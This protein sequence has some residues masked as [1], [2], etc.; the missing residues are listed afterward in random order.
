[1][2][3]L[4]PNEA[5][6]L[7][8]LGHAYQLLR[9][10]PDAI[11]QFERARLLDP[12]YG[13]ANQQLFQIHVATQQWQQA[14]L[15]VTELLRCDAGFWNQLRQ[16]QV[17]LAQFQPEATDN[18]QRAE[19]ERQISQQLP[20]LIAEI[21]E[22]DQA[23]SLLDLAERYQ[24][25]PLLRQAI[26]QALAQ[27]HGPRR[28]LRFWLEHQYQQAFNRWSFCR[29]LKPQVQP[30]TELLLLRGLLEFVGETQNAALLKWLLASY[31]AQCHRDLECWGLVGY[32]QLNLKQHKQMRL[33]LADWPERQGLQP[34][35]LH[36]LLV[37]C[38]ETQN[39]AEARRVSAQLAEF[40]EHE[41]DH[42]I[43]LAIDA[44]LAADAIRLKQQLALVG[45]SQLS[46]YFQPRHQLLQTHL[47]QR[48]S[49]WSWQAQLRQLKRVH[50]GHSVYI[51]YANNCYVNACSTER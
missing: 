5:V 40:P 3:R 16:L 26:P 31:K 18:P 51:T 38:Y 23:E 49:F 33:W 19:L 39:Y 24:A 9:Q 44:A 17:L 25:Q 35:I 14:Q 48:V 13:F 7:G 32:V 42:R 50:R 47:Q 46:S 30:E 34:W 41:P 27:G 11:L 28:L 22:S 43:L 10:Y 21:T 12:S 37:V 8:Y 6:A 2:V 20:G 15:A 1:M 4:A 45:A 36:N 29:W